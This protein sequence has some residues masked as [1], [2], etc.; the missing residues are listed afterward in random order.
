M[1]KTH[2]CY[3]GLGS[4]LGDPKQNVLAAIS[5]IGSF[6]LTD[7][8]SQ[9]SLYKTAPIGMDSP[10]LF[11]NAVCEI[12]T[13]LGPRGLLE[14]CLG[15]E[16][17]F[18]RDRA[19]GKDRELDVDILYYSNCIIWEYDLKIPHPRLS[20]RSFVLVPWSEIAGGLVLRPWG[21]SIIDLMKGIDLIGIEEIS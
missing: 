15:L 12:R 21:K 16:K 17:A 14:L 1:G 20:Q 9:S 6:P 19:R 4:N 3:L 5:R 2:L 11:V 8:S 10:N 13:D 18:G 7:L